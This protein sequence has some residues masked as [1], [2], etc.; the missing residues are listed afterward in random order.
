METKASTRNNNA[1]LEASHKVKSLLGAG[2][3]HIQSFTLL[4]DDTRRQRVAPL[5]SAA[6][7]C[8]RIY[9]STALWQEAPQWQVGVFIEFGFLL[10]G[11]F[12][13][14]KLDHVLLLRVDVFCDLHH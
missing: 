9:Y 14:E 6:V 1:H 11:S 4:H 10:K 12:G 5:V 3:P 8:S 13:Q 7:S 2:C